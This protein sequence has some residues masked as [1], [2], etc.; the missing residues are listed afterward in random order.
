MATVQPTRSMPVGNSEND[1]GRIRNLVIHDVPAGKKYAWLCFNDTQFTQYKVPLGEVSTVPND[2]EREDW[3][4]VLVPVVPARYTIYDA[5][6]KKMQNGAKQLENGYLYIFVNGYLWRELEIYKLGHMRDVNLTIYQND[7]DRP[8]TGDSD[9]RVILPFKVDGNKPK[10]QVCYS[11]TQWCWARINAIGGMDQNDPRLN[12]DTKMP[13][14]KQK[15]SSDDLRK[16]RMGPVLDLSGYK[17][18]FNDLN[19]PFTKADNCKSFFARLHHK[20]EIPILFLHDPLNIVSENAKKYLAKLQLLKSVIALAQG[21]GLAEDQEITK[22][23]K[24]YKVAVL[25]YHTFFDINKTS[26]PIATCY[27]MDTGKRKDIGFLTDARDELDLDYIKKILYVE[28]RKKLRTELRKLKRIHVEWLRGNILV[29]IGN[30]RAEKYVSA[31]SN[32]KQSEYF[33]DFNTAIADYFS[34]ENE[35]YVEGFSAFVGATS[36]IQSD[37]SM[38]DKDMDLPDYDSDKPLP[39]HDPGFLYLSDIM[40]PD[41]ELH[42]MI[43]PKPADFDPYSEDT[44]KFE[45]AD[46]ESD[47]SGVFRKAAFAHMYNSDQEI[48]YWIQGTRRAMQTGKLI[49]TDLMSVMKNQWQHATNLRKTLEEKMVRLTK[50][51]NDP[52][53]KGIHIVEKGTN[54]KGKRIIDGKARIITN[55]EQTIIDKKTGMKSTKSAKHID[56]FEMLSS[57]GSV[58]T[59]HIKKLTDIPVED[60]P[61]FKGLQ[62]GY[63]NKNFHNTFHEHKGGKHYITRAR[64]IVIPEISPLAVYYHDPSADFSKTTEY[65]AIAYKSGKYA[66]P[67]IVVFFEILNVTLAFNSISKNNNLRNKLDVVDAIL[68]LMHSVPEGMEIILGRDRAASLF[69]H[70]ASKLVGKRIAAASTHLLFYKEVNT[71]LGA[72]RL[73]NVLGAAF[74]GLSAVLATWDCVISVQ[75][76]DYG[77]AVGYAIM[78]AGFIGLA[79]ASLATTSSLS[80]FGPLGWIAM[81]VVAL[82]VILVAWL[83]RSD[84]TR[85]AEDGS[86]GKGKNG[87]AVGI[88]KGY[89][90]DE[91]Y[92]AIASLLMRPQMTM[93]REVN[94]MSYS[95]GK[96]GEKRYYKDVVVT[97]TLP[98]FE[99]GKSAV[100]VRVTKQQDSS[101]PDQWLGWSKQ[102]RVMPHKMIQVRDPK[103]GQL[104]AVKYYF[105][106]DH[107]SDHDWRAKGKIETA[108]NLRIPDIPKSKI[109]KTDDS[110]TIDTDAPGWVYA[111]ISTDPWT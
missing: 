93:K 13:S 53:T 58:E 25:A 101:G 92:A 106:N 68:G 97:I 63:G 22:E 39:Q 12:S 36:F 86:L 6:I 75:N 29:G 17:N 19:M 64:Y 27:G 111:E 59:K 56:L 21:E 30:G 26:E 10:V 81:A 16:K 11:Q 31:K 45:L 24:L 5:D 78:T 100:D 76:G 99:I 87:K 72:T 70:Q 85:W 2:S 62:T 28:D 61:T 91:T 71:V 67:G 38:F 14:T 74:A 7:D 32:I 84:L 104:V 65:K 105:L 55:I 33:I 77:A 83:S 80:I 79:V 40:S 15:A 94:P 109:K 49:V 37:P 34:K 57:D 103:S 69:R 9:N 66:L 4:N 44:V 89:S 41:H 52:L 3:E 107:N 46:E 102:K 98:L 35:K 60:I 95:I 48:E 1:N 50:A 54:I 96:V 73:L 88:Y 20:K 90:A 18:N 108:K 51:A 47:G 82:G 110:N 43:F 23:Q 42:E 8:S